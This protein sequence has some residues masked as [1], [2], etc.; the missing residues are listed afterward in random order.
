[1]DY[2]DKPKGVLTIYITYGG[3]FPTPSAGIIGWDTEYPYIQTGSEATLLLTVYNMS[4]EDITSI[5]Y[6]YS[7][8]DWSGTDTYT[9]ATP[10]APCME[11]PYVF[12]MKF[13]PATLSGSNRCLWLSQRLTA[14]P[15]RVNAQAPHSRLSFANWCRCNAP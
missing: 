9:P 4:D 1:M 14:S 10:L 3:D 13:K 6:T 15:I 7:I 12:D 8:G 5:E 2:E 11:T